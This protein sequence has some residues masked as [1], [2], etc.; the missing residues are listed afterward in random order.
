MN[1]YCYYYPHEKE[2]SMGSRAEY[3][4]P[5]GTTKQLKEIFVMPTAPFGGQQGILLYSFTITGIY[6][7]RKPVM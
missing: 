6:S 3:Q 4:Q 7:G 1:K 5:A 2:K